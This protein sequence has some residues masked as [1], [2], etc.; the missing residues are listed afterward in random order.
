MLRRLSTRF[1][2]NKKDRANGINDTNDV[3]NG[4]DTNGASTNG[5][6]AGKPAL[7]KRQSSFGFG[8][9]KVKAQST[10]HAASRSDVQNSF[11]QFAQ[12]IHASERPLPTQTGDGSYLDHKEPSGLM[13]DVRALGFKDVRTLV[14]VMKNKATGELQDDKTY[15]MEH[16]IQVR[17]LKRVRPM[18]CS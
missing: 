13:A 2:K 14:D 3:T 7:E 5:V 10:D 17:H 8:T 12:L 6:S 16:T 4:T 15:L 1:G 11:E 18:I 9:K